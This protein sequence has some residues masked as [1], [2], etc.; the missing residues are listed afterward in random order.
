M[1]LDKI[2]QDFLQYPKI[3]GGSSPACAGRPEN[4]TPWGL[5][6]DERAIGKQPWPGRPRGEN[7]G[8]RKAGLFPF[9]Q[10]DRKPS[11]AG[12][13]FVYDTVT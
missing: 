9:M 13:G 5:F 1:L 6:P 7:T 12:A 2:A 10:T 11:P 8:G 4:R 3:L